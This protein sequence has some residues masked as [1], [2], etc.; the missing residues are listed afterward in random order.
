MNTSKRLKIQKGI[1]GEGTT[2]LRYSSTI[3]R[4]SNRS[5]EMKKAAA[6]PELFPASNSKFLLTFHISKHI[7]SRFPIHPFFVQ[8]TRAQNFSQE[9]FWS[10]VL[11]HI[12]VSEQEKRPAWKLKY[13]SAG[14]E[15]KES[16][17]SVRIEGAVTS[18]T[19][20]KHLSRADF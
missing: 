13:S 16:E 2:N 7:C 3:R 5:A 8:T 9:I 11:T 18:W 6:F 15:P 20:L 1:Y 19:Q 12:L 14:E 17:N 10:Y 4:K